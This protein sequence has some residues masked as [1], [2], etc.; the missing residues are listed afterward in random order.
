MDLTVLKGGKP[1]ESEKMKVK[2]SKIVLERRVM[3]SQLVLQKILESNSEDI[4]DL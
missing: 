1:F 2:V 4:P 3:I